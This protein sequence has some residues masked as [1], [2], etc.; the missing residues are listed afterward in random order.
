MK[1]GTLALARALGATAL[2]A[3][4]IA[5][6][7]QDTLSPADRWAQVAACAA[8]G[9]P[10][11]RHA[12]V[13]GILRAA[14]VL[15]PV[16][17]QAQ[18]RAEF[19]RTERD[20]REPETPAP[21]PVPVAPPVTVAAPPPPPPAPPVPERIDSIS[22]TIAAARVG[23]NGRLLV[24]TAEATVWR[25]LDGEAFRVAP[26]PGTAFA[27]QRGALGSYICTVGRSNSF[28]CARVD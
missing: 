21:V 24:A 25:Q 8:Q 7:A 4:A 19:G 18:Q 14:G 1:I 22:T 6:Q 9:N 23:N 26:S 12:C 5:V 16:R 10:E 27:V 20:L 17:E 3:T 2:G 13:D 15:D 11:R 28:R